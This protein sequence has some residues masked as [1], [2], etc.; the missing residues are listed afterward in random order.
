MD[1]LL[2]G[3]G[4]LLVITSAAAAIWLVRR[5]W[6]TRQARR[7]LESGDEEGDGAVPDEAPMHLEA[8][9][10]PSLGVALG[11][12][13]VCA[14][15]GLPWVL[16]SGIALVAGALA[17]VAFASLTKK[18]A[19]RLEEGL[20]EVVGLAAAAVRAGASPVDALDRASREVREPARSIFLD[21]AGRLRLG[22]DGVAAFEALGQRVPLETYRLFAL[23]LSVQ[24]RSGGSL[25]RTLSSVARAI[26]D[27]VELDRRIDTQ[28][29]PTRA[30][31]FAFVVATVGIAYLMWLNDPINMQ[32][33]LAAPT[34][35]GLVGASLWLQAIG[36]LWMWRLSQLRV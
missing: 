2:G 20:A 13:L 7:R 15:F 31:V 26:R 22:H 30:S 4:A 8:R 23:T 16:W 18:R 11:A 33:F 9:V 1:A 29:A 17:H 35:S 12:A 19:L 3:L 24:W 14:P 36:I 10:W 6:W 34:G 28:S 21:L 25:D 5:E 27:R 32:S